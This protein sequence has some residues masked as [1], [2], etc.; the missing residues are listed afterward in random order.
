[1]LASSRTPTIIV[2]APSDWRVDRV[3]SKSRKAD[4]SGKN[5]QCDVWQTGP[6]ALISHDNP[7]SCRSDVLCDFHGKLKVLQSDFTHSPR[8]SLIVHEASTHTST[9]CVSEVF[10]HMQA[11]FVKRHGESTM[12]VARQDSCVFRSASSNVQFGSL[13]AHSGREAMTSVGESACVLKGKK[14][15]SRI[16]ALRAALMAEGV[17]FASRYYGPND[18][19]GENGQMVKARV[20]GPDSELCELRGLE[21]GKRHNMCVFSE[22]LMRLARCR[23]PYWLSIPIFSPC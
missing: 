15:S 7:T 14:L 21:K 12:A 16:R 9:V 6:I 17:V 3:V 2:V 11:V 13:T 5:R 1:M 18:D 19:R 20:P 4:C 8:L 22:F 10:A 23:L